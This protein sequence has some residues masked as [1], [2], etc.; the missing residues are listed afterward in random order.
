MKKFSSVFI[1]FHTDIMNKYIFPVQQKISGNFSENFLEIFRNI[2]FR[3]S[4]ITTS[5]AAPS[6]PLIAPIL[7]EIVNCSLNYSVFLQV[8][9]TA[10]IV[11]IY[12]KGERDDPTN[13][14]PYIHLHTSLFLQIF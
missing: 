13:S 10:K 1:C 5:I 14:S 2:F 12:K 4:Y 3:K 11:P 9:K 6:M 7:T 8:V